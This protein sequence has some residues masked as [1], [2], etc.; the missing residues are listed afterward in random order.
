MGKR[1]AK[2]EPT[3]A[4]KRRGIEPKLEPVTVASKSDSGAPAASSGDAAQVAVKLESEHPALLPGTDEESARAVVLTD[5]QKAVVALAK[6]P[7]MAAREGELYRIPA[8]AGTGKVRC[9]HALD[10]GLYSV[11]SLLVLFRDLLFEP[12][13]LRC[14]VMCE[15]ILT[16]FGR[17]TFL[18]R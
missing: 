12:R 17:R 16:A 1:H 15:R 8:A 14:F 9:I 4:Q 7:R 10:C 2:S 3:S 13:E 5:Q 6:A 18:M 11:S